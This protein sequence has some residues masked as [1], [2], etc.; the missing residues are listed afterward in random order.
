[1]CY[2][3]TSYVFGSS[4]DSQLENFGIDLDVLKAKVHTCTFRA[5]VEDWEYDAIKDRAVAEAHLLENHKDLMFYDPDSENTY[6]I[7]ASNLQW[8]KASKRQN[9]TGGWHGIGTD[10][11]DENE[12]FEIEDELL[13]QMADI[14]QDPSIKMSRKGKVA[15]EG[16]KKKNKSKDLVCV[17]IISC[18]TLQFYKIF[19][20]A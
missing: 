11:D 20:T 5:W 18:C 15:E 7:H 9:I 1:M 13:V 14:P 19:V 3:L 2:E 16:K 17:P 6:K 4:F 12:S 8:Y 10:E